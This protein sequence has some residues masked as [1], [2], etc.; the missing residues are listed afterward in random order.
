MRNTVLATQ[1]VSSRLLSLAPLT[2]CG[3]Q[4]IDEATWRV[5]RGV[6]R[7]CRACYAGRVPGH[8]GRAEGGGWLVLAR[9]FP[10]EGGIRRP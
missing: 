3:T 1:M 8:A 9:S 10:A 2:R 5:I 4:W 7:V 6:R